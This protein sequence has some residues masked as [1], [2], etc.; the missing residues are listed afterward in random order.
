MTLDRSDTLIFKSYLESLHSSIGAFLRVLE[1]VR[2]QT[3]SDRYDGLMLELSAIQPILRQFSAEIRKQID[4]S[5][6]DV[7]I[8]A[9]EINAAI[10][11]VT[12]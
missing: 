7:N 5:D 3:A 10:D 8:R 9:A 6:R 12:R 4:A 11:N 2:A 1:T